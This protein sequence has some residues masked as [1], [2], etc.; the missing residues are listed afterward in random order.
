[1]TGFQ[2][3][4]ELGVEIK[5]YCASEIDEQAI[6]V[7]LYFENRKKWW[8]MLSLVETQWERYSVSDTSY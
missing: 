8:K 4:K 7:G 5:V 3:L 1:M 6:Q 2:A